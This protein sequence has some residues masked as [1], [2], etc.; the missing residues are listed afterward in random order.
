MDALGEVVDLGAA[1]AFAAG[2]LASDLD[3]HGQLLSVGLP[4]RVVAQ[5][6]RVLEGSQPPEWFTRLAGERAGNR[7]AS[8]PVCCKQLV[9][10]G[11]E[12]S[13]DAADVS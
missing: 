4:P 13:P 1:R 3:W 8:R 6:L 11:F 2:C 12:A 9:L 5:G 10:P 7:D